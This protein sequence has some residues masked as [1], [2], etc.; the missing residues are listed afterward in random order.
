[1]AARHQHVAEKVRPWLAR[2]R[3]VLSDRYADATVAYQGYGRGIDP[4]L[5]RELNVRA[6]GGVLPDLTLLFDVDPAEGF[7]RIGARRRDHFEREALAFAQA[8]L[9]TGGREA[10]AVGGWPE[11]RREAGVPPCGR[12]QGCR[13]AAAR[14]HP[15]L[16]L[17]APTPPETNPKGARAIRIDAIRGLERQA[18]LRPVMAPRKLFVLD[19]AERMTGEAAQALLKTLEEP[20]AGTVLILVLPRARARA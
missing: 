12:C 3:V 11:P 9:C 6:T 10:G 15:D 7:R 16:H 20:P 13:L 18:A 4:D 1:M 5:I 2:G 8:L 17:I 14:V 19:E